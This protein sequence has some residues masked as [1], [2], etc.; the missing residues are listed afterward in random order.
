MFKKINNCVLVVLFLAILTLPLL[1]T[2]WESGG[3]SEAE[4]RNLAKFPELIEDGSFNMAFT[5]LFEDWFM[6]HLGFRKALI[7]T[8]ETLMQ[9]VFKRD[10]T[11]SEWKTGKTGDS[12]YAPAFIIEDFAHTNLR[13][14]EKVAAIGNSYQTISDYLEKKG[15]PFYYVQCVD[16]HTIYPERFI[17]HVRQVGDI[18]KTDQVMKYLKNE[19]TVNVIYLKDPMWEA[20]EE[21]GVFSHWGDAAHWTDRGA[22]ISYRYMMERINRDM[23][24]PLKVLQEDAYKITYRTKEGP[25]GQTEQIE[26][27]TIIEP[28]AQSVDTAVLGKWSGDKRHTVWK[29]PEAGNDK[30]LLLMGDSYIESFLIEDFA[31]SFG[32]VWMVWG[33]Y[34]QELPEIV[35]FCDPDM[36][37]LECAERV[38]RSSGVCAL[39][40]KLQSAG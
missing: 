33:D 20:R 28:K 23:D 11:T 30:R 24:V 32:E 37:W 18:S 26:V 35:E 31:E 17:P 15:I 16:K 4:N 25:D 6:D 19:T 29:N 10:L 8:N 34:I 12:I 14:P 36:V 21:Y 7:E 13:T 3:T 1:F 9:K 22:Y 39:A 27:F 40:E 38:D 2:R 5:Q